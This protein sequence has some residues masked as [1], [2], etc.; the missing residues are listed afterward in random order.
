MPAETTTLL[1]LPAV[2][3]RTGV[4]RTTLFNLIQRDLFPAPVRIRNTRI[5]AWPSTAVDAWIHN[6]INGD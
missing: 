1:R 3:E 4:K 6:Q 2:L 5:R